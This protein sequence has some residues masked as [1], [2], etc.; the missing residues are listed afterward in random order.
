MV[1]VFSIPA[2]VPTT[3]NP[4]LPVLLIG[5]TLPSSLLF[6]LIEGSLD[7]F[8][9]TAMTFHHYLDDFDGHC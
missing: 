5:Y 7:N 3:I 1:L 4:C 9:F 2:F 6:L 8:C